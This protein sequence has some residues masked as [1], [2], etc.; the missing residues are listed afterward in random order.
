MM[1][2][3]TT[4]IMEEKK[5]PTKETKEGRT[6]EDNGREKERKNKRGQ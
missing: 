4:T 1:K 3:K 2:K 6:K 5:M